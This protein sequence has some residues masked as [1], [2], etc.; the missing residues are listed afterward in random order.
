MNTLIISR[1]FAKNIFRVTSRRC[2]APWTSS[3]DVK[4]I[5]SDI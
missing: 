4:M 3:A 2:L 1:Y 5:C